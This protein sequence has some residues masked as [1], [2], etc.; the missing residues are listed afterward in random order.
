MVIYHVSTCDTD[1]Q[2]IAHYQS[3]VSPLFSKAGPDGGV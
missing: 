1:Y 3:D 2:I